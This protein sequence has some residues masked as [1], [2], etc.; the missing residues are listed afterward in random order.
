MNNA[1]SLQ[2]SSSAM[3]NNSSFNGNESS[4][5]VF[6]NLNK[7]NMLLTT[8]KEDSKQNSDKLKKSDSN[9]QNVLIKERKTNIYQM[10]PKENTLKA[11]NVYSEESER[12]LEK[13]DKIVKINQN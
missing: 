3:L 13:K 5:N 10:L 6:S 4:Q 2:I 7:K 1:S 9:N 8:I 11:S 12:K